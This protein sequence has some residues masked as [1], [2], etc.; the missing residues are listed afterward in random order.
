MAVKACLNGGRIRKEHPA[1]PQTPAELAADTIAVQRAGAFAVHVHP[2]KADGSQTLDARQCDATAAAIRAA[3]P[4]MAIGFSTAETIDADPFA[5]AFALRSWRQP[6]DF[7]SVNL[8]EPGWAGIAR[9][10]RHAG[11]AVEAGLA[12]PADALALADS[13]FAHQLIRALIEV[14][15]G[16]AEARAVSELVPPGVPQLWHGYGA[17]TW[18]VI[19]AAIAAGHD[20]RVGLED[21]LVLPDGELAASNAQLVMAA[22]KLTG[23]LA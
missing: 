2:R 8:S 12:T 17:N 23:Q 7:V 18:E 20:V 10:A 21:V 22:V 11:I 9:A 16:A 6:P 13:S 1:V 14:D 15:A 5:R 19:A 3:V 4:N